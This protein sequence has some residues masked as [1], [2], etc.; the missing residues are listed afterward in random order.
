MERTIV[1]SRRELHRAR[2]LEQVLQGA[3]NLKEARELLQVSYR[4]V[5]RYKKRYCQHGTEGLAHGNRGR[6]VAHAL[7]QDR[8]G[9]VLGLYE[10]KYRKFN[11]THFTEMLEEQESI[12]LSRETVRRILRRAG[13][14]PKRRRRAPRH[15]AR[16]P[17]K[18]QRGT[19]IQWDGS[20]HCWFGVDRPPCCLMAAID[21]AD[22]KLLAALFVPAESAVAY[23]QLLDKVLQRHGIPLSVYHDRHSALERTDTHWSLEEQLLGRQFPTHVGRV[24]ED[25][26]IRAI[27]AH[28]PQAKGRVERC[29]GVLQDRLIAELDLEDITDITT[30]NR[31]LGKSFIPRH[32]QRFATKSLEATSAFRKTS[33]QERYQKIAFAYEATVANDNCVRLGGLIIDIPPGKH[34]R[35]YA[36]AKVLVKQHLDGAWTIWYKNEK[37][38]AHQPT[39]FREPI[40]SWKRRTPGDITGT[41]S[42]IQVYIHSKPAP[43]TKGT[44]SHCS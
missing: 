13:R 10:R 22:S 33:Q 26:S 21:D 23:L 40:R 24:L 3:L 44:L 9:Q 36:K 5:K 1:M 30:A 31:W 25:L 17:R 11:D 4:Q 43:P 35:S 18:T 39:T 6:P 42:M 19:M 16:R 2:V 14:D 20:P 37:I 29:F 34:R 38:A 12:T 8:I 7:T 27:P 15:H 41:R 28:S 32:N